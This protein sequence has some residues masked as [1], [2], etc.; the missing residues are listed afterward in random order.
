MKEIKLTKGKIALVD[1][2]DFG[3]LNKWKW[4]Y[5]LGYAIRRPYEGYV[6]GIKKTSV[7]FMHRLIN[8]TPAGMDTDHINGDKLDNRRCNLR[9]A[10]S[11]QNKQNRPP[12]K[13]MDYKGVSL[14][15]RNNKWRS[16]ISINGDC[17]FLGY[18]K[19]AAEAALAYNNA[20]VLL[21]KEFAYLNEV[22]S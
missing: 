20:A 5:H 4:K 21:H 9:T 11:G 1:D 15:K 13:G 2:D 16:Y 14:D 10:S 6:D 17:K 18:F 8:D 19:T 22:A 7:L 12:F 3:F